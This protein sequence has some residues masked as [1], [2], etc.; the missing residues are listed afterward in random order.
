MFT[1]DASQ[2]V[3]NIPKTALHTTA[4]ALRMLL[5]TSTVEPNVKQYIADMVS[6]DTRS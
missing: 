2:E 3:N 1:I 6:T 4:R 5:L